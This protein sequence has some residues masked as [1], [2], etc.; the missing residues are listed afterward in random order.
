MEKKPG[1]SISAATSRDWQWAEWPSYNGVAKGQRERHRLLHFRRDSERERRGAQ[2]RLEGGRWDG[3]IQRT[4][5]KRDGDGERW[6]QK[7]CHERRR[8][9]ER[10]RVHESLEA[11]TSSTQYWL[12]STMAAVFT[13]VV[14]VGGERRHCVR[15]VE[16]RGSAWPMD[17]G[18]MGTVASPRMRGRPPAGRSRGTDELSPAGTRTDVDGVAGTDELPRNSCGSFWECFF[19]LVG[20]ASSRKV[21]SRCACTSA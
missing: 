15:R 11:T 10:V 1:S 20:P 8:R 16:P 6:Q 2:Q 5:R 9:E 18:C 3:N 19:S 4:R 7:Q 13:G 14:V 21:A 12:P 17:H